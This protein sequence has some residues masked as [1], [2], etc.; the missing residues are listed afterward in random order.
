[1]LKNC[2][3][4]DNYN[5]ALRWYTCT[6]AVYSLFNEI[7]ITVNALPAVLQP[8]E[9]PSELPLIRGRPGP[10]YFHVRGNK[11]SHRKLA[12]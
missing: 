4:I 12:I 3:E 8:S 6:H 10:L 1:M 5:A 2:F 11:L 7:Y 9:L